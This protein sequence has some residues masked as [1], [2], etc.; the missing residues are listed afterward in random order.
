MRAVVHDRYGE[1]EVLRVE[2]VERPAPA[3]ARSLVRVHATTVTRTDCHM[4]QASPFI[5]RFMLGLLRP[6]RKILGLEF[7]GVVEA[8]GAA[9]TE[10]EAGDRV[11]GLGT[12]RT[13]STSACAR[14]ASWRTFPRA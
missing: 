10:F 1:P 8:V 6:R 14:P 4:R 5:W 12:A 2:E 13:P 11:F 3:R 7:A 9:V